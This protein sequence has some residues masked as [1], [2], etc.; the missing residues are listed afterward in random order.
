[1]VHGS[2]EEAGCS[3]PGP[4]Y[5]CARFLT[6]KSDGKALSKFMDAVKELIVEFADE[7]AENP[8]Q[9]FDCNLKLMM[10]P[11][12][13]VPMQEKTEGDCKE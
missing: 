12:N 2:Q 13:L 11:C 10:E 8:D 5:P 6:E 4:E 1:M 7:L 3:H 9:A